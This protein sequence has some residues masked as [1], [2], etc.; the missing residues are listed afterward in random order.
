VENVP[1]KVNVHVHIN[2][3]GN[4][5]DVLA[6]IEDK[7]VLL[8]STLTLNVKRLKSTL[9]A[10]FAGACNTYQV[11]YAPTNQ[12]TNFKD[13]QANVIEDT[14]FICTRQIELHSTNSDFFYTR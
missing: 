14:G 12:L 7:R 6:V 11:P 3:E 9:V 5:D 13:C 4:D 8:S 2:I 1:I 10:S